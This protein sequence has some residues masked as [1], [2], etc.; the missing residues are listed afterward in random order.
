MQWLKKK[1]IIIIIF[2]KENK[3]NGT[4]LNEHTDFID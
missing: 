2:R 4:I 3:R 1:N